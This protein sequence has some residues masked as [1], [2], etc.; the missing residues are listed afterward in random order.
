MINIYIHNILRVL[1]PDSICGRDRSCQFPSSGKATPRLAPSLRPYATLI[2]L[3]P[4]RRLRLLPTDTPL[5]PWSHT[6]GQ[7]CEFDQGRGGLPLYLLLQEYN[8][9][10]LTHTLVTAVFVWLLRLM[11]GKVQVQG[12]KEDVSQ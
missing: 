10:T 5:A 8:G 12:S 3:A 11:D 1:S 6:S 2:G 7:S 4:S 9:D